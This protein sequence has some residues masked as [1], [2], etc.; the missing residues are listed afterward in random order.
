MYTR[1][2]TNRFIY[3]ANWLLG[4]LPARE[5]VGVADESDDESERD[6]QLTDSGESADGQVRSVDLGVNSED[7]SGRMRLRRNGRDL[8]MNKGVEYERLADE[9][10]FEDEDE[11]TDSLWYYLVRNDG[12]GIKNVSE[13]RCF[14]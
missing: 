4:E 7:E 1:S 5:K 3:T 8:T 10:V 6:L 14:V 2:H 13:S 9:I 11:A 12:L